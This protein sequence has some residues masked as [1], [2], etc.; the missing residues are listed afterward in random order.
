MKQCVCV[1]THMYMEIQEQ[2]DE[3]PAPLIPGEGIWISDHQKVHTFPFSY[4]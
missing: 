2:R 3:I 4:L 1:Y